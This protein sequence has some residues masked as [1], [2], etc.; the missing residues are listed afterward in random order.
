MEEERD[1]KSAP[2]VG[3]LFGNV[4]ENQRVDADYLDEVRRGRCE[5]LGAGPTLPSA[6]S[7]MAPGAHSPAAYP[8]QDAKEH[9]GAL[10]RVKGGG[11]DLQASAGEGCCAVGALPRPHSHAPV[12]GPVCCACQCASLPSGGGRQRRRRHPPPHPPPPA[13]AGGAAR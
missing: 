7:L 4:D 3:F 11:L 2:L 8:L 5:R 6:C 1:P 13:F 12:I 9:L 10:A